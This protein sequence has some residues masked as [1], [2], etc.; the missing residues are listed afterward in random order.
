MRNENEVRHKLQQA[1]FRHLKKRIESS[2]K[3]R[4]CNCAFNETHRTMSQTANG[5]PIALCMYGATDP[6]EWEGVICDDDFGGV[7]Q[8]RDCTL[9]KPRRTKVEIKAE[10]HDLMENGDIS[11]VA[12]KYPDIAALMWVL[13]DRPHKLSLWQRIRLWWVPAH[14][15]PVME[16]EGGDEQDD[17][18]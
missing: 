11:L 10:H 2:Y 12:A 17:P 3:K 13:D 9:F 15:T 7:A 14:V 8:A 4:P 1:Q 6:V 16:N 5:E 18:T